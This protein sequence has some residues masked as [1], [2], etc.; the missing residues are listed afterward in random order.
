M[1]T[2]GV[3]VNAYE[4]FCRVVG[5]ER[6]DRYLIVNPFFHA[7]GYKAGWLSCLIVGAA[8][9]PLATF[10]VG[11]VLRIIAQEH[12]TV[13]PGPPT[14]YWSM[15]ESRRTR[16]QEL[17]SLRLSITGSTTVP[18]ELVRRMQEELTFQ[19]ICV[20]Y[21]LTEANG[22]GTMC[23]PDDPPAVVTGSSG[24][25]IP[26]MELRIADDGEIL[27]RGHLMKGY[28]EDPKATSNA[29]SADGWLHTG[30]IGWLD[31]GGNL[32]V[33]DRK[34][35]MFIVGGFNVYPAEVESVLLGH[36]AIAQVA[37]V[38]APEDRMGEVGH[39]FVVPRPGAIVDQREVIAWS[40]QRMANF[41]VPRRVTVCQEL[42]TT[43]NGK[44]Q[45]AVLR[46][47]AAGRWPLGRN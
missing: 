19:H 27:L 38:G 28:L 13:F 7:F 14:I 43:A 17:A 12:I 2:H 9:Y 36:P 24:R 45:K 25:P 11:D 22:L 21:G 23:R 18:T 44:V 5:M 32:H 37:V 4:T 30:D 10:D 20:G 15:M 31:D 46:Q 40:R 47:W 26:G 42:P 29:M 39:A 6:G 3:T 8:A 34:K 35:D 33:T 1:C 41:K 16:R